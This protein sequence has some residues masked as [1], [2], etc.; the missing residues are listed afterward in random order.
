[1]SRMRELLLDEYRVE[2]LSHGMDSCRNFEHLLESALQQC[3]IQPLYDFLYS[4]LKDSL[5][6]SGTFEQ[7]RE[8]IKNAKTKT[9]EDL[10]IRVSIS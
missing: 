4:R 7:V 6:A 5:I 2:L 8:A 10:A 1:M 9:Q 3:I